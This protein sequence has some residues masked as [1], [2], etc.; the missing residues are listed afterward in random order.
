[1]PKKPYTSP[2]L[3]ELAEQIR[4][5]AELDVIVKLEGLGQSDVSRLRD[6]VEPG[7]TKQKSSYT[8]E[9]H[10]T[11]LRLHEQGC[12]VG[13]LAKALGRSPKSVAKYLCKKGLCLASKRFRGIGAEQQRWC[14]ELVQLRR[15]ALG[16][17]KREAA[18]KLGWEALAWKRHEAGNSAVS[19]PQMRMMLEVLG[20][21]LVWAPQQ[22]DVD[23]EQELGASSGASAPAAL[24]SMMQT[25]DGLAQELR[26]RRIT[27][28]RKQ[29]EQGEREGIGNSVIAN[30]ELGRNGERGLRL[31]VVLSWAAHLELVPML[32]LGSQ[33]TRWLGGMVP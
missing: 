11:M 26:A 2:R 31:H 16:L 29:S 22:D 10:A 24:I 3:A 23:Q 8:A 17:S 13:E 15:E 19:Q 12:D 28:G 27:L 5:G 7:R 4:A 6:L 33:Q 30:R 9:E 32:V 21:E 18:A 20:L 1:M 14:A 25:A